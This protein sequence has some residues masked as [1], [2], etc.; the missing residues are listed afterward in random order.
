MLSGD[1]V[2]ELPDPAI[3]KPGSVPK[4]RT[5][6]S[7]SVVKSLTDVLRQFEIDAQVTGYTRGPTVTRYE[8]ELG[9]AVK[10]EKV[11]ALAKNIAYAVASADV[12]ILSPIPGKSAIGI[13]IPNADGKVL[14]GI[15][16]TAM[17]TMGTVPAHLLPQ[18]VLTLNDEGTLGVRSVPAVAIDGRL[19]DCCAGRGIDEASLRAAGWHLLGTR[20]GGAWSRPSRPRADTPDHLRGP[21]CL[22]QAPGGAD[23]GKR[24]DAD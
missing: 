22:W 23:K 17:V 20:G 12:R 24:P 16:A 5:A 2:Y 11:T 10:V 19:A 6:A 18:S 7:D 4:A 1:V 13:E 8:V 9:K 3:L 15:T 21:K 14:S